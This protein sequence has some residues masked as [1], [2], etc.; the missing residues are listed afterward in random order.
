MDESIAFFLPT[1]K[2]SQRVTSKNTRPFAG[3]EGGLLEIK[4]KQLLKTRCC[5]EII[6]STDDPRSV[7]V[8]KAFDRPDKIKIVMRPESLC[9]STTLVQDLIDYVPTAVSAAHVFWLHVTTPFV[10]TEDYDLAC[11]S[12]FQALSDGYDSLMSV[13]RF[14][15]F[16]W[17]EEKGDVINFDRNKILW[18]NTQDLTP[19]YEINHAFYISSRDNFI[20]LRDRIGKKPK[21]W[22]LTGDKKVD[23]DWGEDFELAEALYLLRHEND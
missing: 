21:L 9:L 23:I 2:G 1:R 8:A 19:L 12:Y 20:R 10:S 4:L 15:Q 22:E 5:G 6:L 3:I 17:S 14:Q 11:D 16:L 7:E 13:T 18:P